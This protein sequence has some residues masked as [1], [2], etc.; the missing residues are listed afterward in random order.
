MN[1]RPVR[2]NAL[3]YEVRVPLIRS[4]L[5]PK[6][7][8]KL[9]RLITVP[10]ML[11][12]MMRSARRDRHFATERVSDHPQRLSKSD[13]LDMHEQCKTIPCQHIAAATTD[14]GAAPFAVIG[15]VELGSGFDV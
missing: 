8:R 12:L 15:P 1:T 4:R 6:L 14:K 13:A 2:L 7:S 9:A 3:I 10:V 5:R 11:G